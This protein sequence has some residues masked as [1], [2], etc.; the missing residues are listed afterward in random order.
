MSLTKRAIENQW[1]ENRRK[2][3]CDH[4]VSKRSRCEECELEQW[5]EYD[6]DD[7]RYAVSEPDYGGAFDGFTVSSDADP[8]YRRER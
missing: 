5:A 2:G 8:G 3:L 1:A 4:G 7:F 6:D